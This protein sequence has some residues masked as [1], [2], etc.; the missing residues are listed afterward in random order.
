MLDAR[1]RFLALGHYAPIV[2]ALAAA[3]LGAEPAHDVDPAL[4]GTLVGPRIVDAGCGTGFYL[5]E[6]LDRM[7]GAVGLAADLAPAAV[8]AAVRGRHDVDGVVADTWSGLPLRDASAD[9]LLDVFAPRNMTEFHRVL[10]PYGRVAIVAA[11]T[12]HLA[13]LR[14]DG[15]A[16]GVQPD[17]RERILASADGLFEVESETRVNAPLELTGAEVDLLLGMG[18]SAHHAPERATGQQPPSAADAGLA[19]IPAREVCQ[20]VTLDVMVHV[21]RRREARDSS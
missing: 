11:G 9:L 13:E 15:R 12:D 16:V 17:K 2:D 20:V 4:E 1:A 7:P 6:L 10:A 18:P 21:L 8:S 19:S 3:V 5:H 14:A